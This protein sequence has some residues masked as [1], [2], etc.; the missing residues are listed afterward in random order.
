MTREEF[1]QLQLK[2]TPEI[3]AMLKTA[4][5]NLRTMRF[6]LIAGKVKNVGALRELRKDIARM[7]TVLTSIN[8]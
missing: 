2:Q 5:E 3:E 8:K 7:L 4:R 6:D 1:K